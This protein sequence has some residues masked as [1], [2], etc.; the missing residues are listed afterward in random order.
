[1]TESLVLSAAGGALGFGLAALAKVALM[2][3]AATALPLFA[4][5][6]IDRTVLLFAVALSLAAPVIFGIAPALSTSRGGGL[7]ERVESTTRET[8]WLRNLLVTGE[9]ALSIV[10]VVGA[11]LLLRS[12]DRLHDVDPGFTRE[13]AITFTMTLPSARYTDNAARHRTFTE[14][15][16]QLRDQQGV[17]AV[18]AS[19][20]IALRGF[21]WTGD[22]AIEGRAATDYER[23]TRHMSTTPSYFST[24]GIRLLAG[25]MFD[26]T[27]IRDKPPVTI[28][29]ETLARRFFPA[30]PNADVIG[31]RVSFGRPQDNA[32][33][34]TIVGVVADEKQD[35]LDRPAEPTEYSPIAQRMQNPLTFVVRTT[36]APQAA[37]AGA[38]ARV[39]AVDKDLALTQT[40]TLEEVVDLSLAEARF[41]TTLLTWF[42]GIALLLAALGIYGVLAY[43][44]SQRSREIGIR[45]ALGAAPAELFRMVIGQGMRPV[46]IGAAVGL[47][48]AVAVTT[49]LQSLLFGVTPVDP[50]AYSAAAAVLTAIAVGA[51]AIPA[52]RATRVDPLVALR[53]E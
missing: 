15:E 51:C 6:Q 10:L 38:R 21:T 4:V 25:R 12:L 28:V 11:V 26:G 14:I 27:D 40:A 46:A 5:V 3:Y 32:P 44:V 41:R 39:A 33:W 48:G 17:Q 47:A 23:D 8:R 45:L 49:L 1:M 31:K 50:L 43:F 24:M 9:V 16:R 19:S 36:I 52:L 34:V 7:T 13:H 37:L 30:L 29:N 22:S 20:T 18:G 53:D 35:G 42:A 2:E